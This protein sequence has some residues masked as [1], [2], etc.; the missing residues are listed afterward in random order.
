[1]DLFLSPLPT[2]PS[3]PTFRVGDVS[4]YGDAI[5]APMDGF[6]DWPF[7]SLCSALGSAMSYT[8]F[9][10]AEFIVGAFE[11]M[12][13]RFKYEQEERPVVFQIYGD[14]PGLLLKAAL[15]V[16][17]LSPDI[18]DINLGCPAKTVANRGAG[19]GLMRTPLK[20]I[21]V[22]PSAP[23]SIE[24]LSTMPGLLPGVST[25]REMID[26]TLF[27]V[28]NDETRFH[29]NGVFF[30]S[31]GSKVRMVSTDGHRLS[32]VERTIANGPKLSAGVIIPK[33]GLLEMKKVL[34]TGAACKLAI[35]TPHLFLVQEDIALAVKLIDAQF[36]P[37]EQVIPKDH[38]RVF[39]EL[40]ENRKEEWIVNF[41]RKAGY[42]VEE[43]A[44]ATILELVENNTDALKTA[45]SRITLFF[46]AGHRVTEADCDAMLAHNREE[47]PFSLSGL[48]H[49][50][51]SVWRTG[52]L[53]QCRCDRRS[54]CRPCPQRPLAYRRPPM[55]HRQIPSEATD[56]AGSRSG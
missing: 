24:M 33:K 11:H 53:S 20:S 1:M 48:A 17:E 2:H 25:M 32:K 42:S 9:V 19:V 55:L 39:W 36:P 50:W 3:S 8:E 5:L 28:C 13:T 12:L 7:R 44:V 6:S 52:W 31:D 41:F 54:H 22:V 26:R 43:D 51:S 35:K 49:C 27:S 56:A 14:D 10:R 47:T 38:K 4:V 34:E 21:R 30:E 18:I 23:S 16:Q 15:M 45:C 46:P 40:F 29:L 37:Y